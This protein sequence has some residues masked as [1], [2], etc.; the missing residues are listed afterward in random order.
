MYKGTHQK[1]V[2]YFSIKPIYFVKICF[3]KGLCHILCVLTN[4]N[5]NLYGKALKKY[6]KRKSLITFHILF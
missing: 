3:N 4:P 5:Y 1:N 6:K 2:V